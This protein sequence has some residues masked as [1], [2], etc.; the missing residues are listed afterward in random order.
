MLMNQLGIFAF[1]FLVAYALIKPADSKPGVEM[2]AEYVVTMTWPKGSLDDI[3][4]HMLLPDGKQV[5]FKS[6]EQGYV[7][8]DHDDVGVNGR[9]VDGNGELQLLEH[10][11]T[12]AVRAIVPG[13]YVVNVH[14]Y[15]T[16][17]STGGR[18]EEVTLP[19]A[20]H[21]TLTKLN[22]SVEDLASV[23]VLLAHVGEQK[24]AFSF[25]VAADGYA[26][27]DLTADRPFIP[28]INTQGLPSVG[29]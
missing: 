3:D 29:N 9:Y 2:K 28:T 16:N 15:S 18:A 8:L 10:K 20:A 1:L 19:Y 6:R 7:V 12:I 5:N 11:E 25:D 27:V 14:V 17:S 4:V 26:H 21:V 23:D 24:T 13:T 22:P